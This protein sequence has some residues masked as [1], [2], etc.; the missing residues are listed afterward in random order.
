MVATRDPEHVKPA[1][2]IDRLHALIGRGVFDF[3]FGFGRSGLSRKV[4]RRDA[5]FL[6]LSITI[7]PN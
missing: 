7:L 3:G 4:G 5:H 1:K 2:D 6:N